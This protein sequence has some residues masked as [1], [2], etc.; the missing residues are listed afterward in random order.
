ML[1][2]RLR[3]QSDIVG[4]AAV[5]RNVGVVRPQ[6]GRCAMNVILHKAEPTDASGVAE[7]YL[8][9]RKT[10]LPFAPLVHSDAEV[11]QWVAD[12]LIPSGGVTVATV[13][14]EPIGMMAVSRD[15]QFGWID[16]LYLHPSAVGRGIGSRLLQRAI[17]ELGPRIRLYTFQANAGSRR[18]YERHGFL[19]I[20]FSDGHTNEEHCP[21]VL[22]ELEL[23]ARPAGGDER[24]TVLAS[25]PKRAYD[26]AITS[27]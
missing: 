5:S 23:G 22:Y 12:V 6:E 24:A 3:F 10:F 14:N 9:S 25:R 4:P 17:Q 16:Q 7:V 1:G 21:D 18:F 11:R 2:L 13:S 8:I 27:A 15:G 20:A 26:K 19:A